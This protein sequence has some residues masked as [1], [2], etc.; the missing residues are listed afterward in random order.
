[1]MKQALIRHTAAFLLTVLLA[2][3]FLLLGA[4]LPQAPI[5]DNIR[6]SAAR[7][8]VEGCYPVMADHAFA[9]TLDYTT[10]A[11]ILAESKATS[12][13]D[14]KTILTNPL[15][16]YDYGEGTAVDHLYQYSMDPAPQPDKFYVQY[17]MGFRPL[18]RFLLCFLD[19]YQIL[20]Y[21]AVVFFVL[22]AAVLCSIASRAGT[23]AAFAFALSIIFVRP[24][25]IAVSLQFSCCFLLAFSAMLLV[26]KIR[27][28]PHWESLFYLELGILTQYFDFYTT[29]VLTFCLPMTYWYLLQIRENTP[30]TLKQIG[31]NAAAWSAGYGFMWLAKLVLTSLLTEANGLGQGLSSFMGR[32]GIEKVSGMEAYYSPMAALRSVAISLYSDQEGKLIL[33]AVLA[34]GILCLAAFFLRKKCSLCVLW[35]HRNLLVLAALPV[36]WFMVAAQPTA[37]HHWF[38]YRSIAASFWAGMSYLLL[39]LQSGPD[40]HAPLQ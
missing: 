15:Y 9:A 19:Y 21:T 10:D 11:L 32:I 7:M 34:L 23:R 36:I 13:A 18:I 26:P 25:V 16:Q 6:T 24:H 30:V 1:M 14:W 28:R 33:V 29:P 8:V 27:Q 2:V 22:F 3:G 5:D 17:W 20:R 4:C 38:Q 12:I 39:S 40:R 35:P 37:N 31:K